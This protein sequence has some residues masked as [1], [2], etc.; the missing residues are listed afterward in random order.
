M[1]L[2][3]RNAVDI[4]KTIH[5]RPKLGESA[6]VEGR[7]PIRICRTPIITSAL[8]RLMTSLLASGLAMWGPSKTGKYLPG[9]LNMLDT[10]AAKRGSSVTSAEVSND[11]TVI[12][13]ILPCQT[14]GIAV[15]LEGAVLLRR[16]RLI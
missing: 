7:L 5:P 11:G 12:M 10:R 2:C 8:L 15:M 1:A 3:V 16:R 4:S 9:R 6:A 14:F 13:V